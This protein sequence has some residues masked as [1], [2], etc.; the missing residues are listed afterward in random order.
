MS[1]WGAFFKV[2]MLVFRPTVACANPP[3]FRSTHQALFEIVSFSKGL[4]K[5]HQGE[6]FLGLRCYWQGL[7]SQETWR[8]FHE[9]GP[10]NL[11]V[12]SSNGTEI[13]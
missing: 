9:I 6:E 13:T 4:G 2:E 1:F 7:R 11:K 5:C 3:S 10:G 12:S 8:I